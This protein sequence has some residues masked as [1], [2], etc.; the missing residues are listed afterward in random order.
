MKDRAASVRARLTDKARESGRPFSEL[1][2][3]YAMERF[4]YR[5]SQLPESDRLLLKG[6]LMLQVWDAPDSRPTRDIDLLAY[7]NNE[8]Q[9]V[10]ALARAACEI[11]V[12]DDGMVFDSATISGQR[13]KEDAD[14]EGVRVRLTGRLSNARVPIQLDVGFGDVVYPAAEEADYPVLLD[15]PA[16]S[17]RVYPRETLIAEKYEAMVRLGEVNSRVKDFFDIWLL[18]RQFD[19]SGD[20]LATAITKTF[21]NRKTEPPASTPVALTE[22]FSSA[23]R[24]Q[25][26]WAA[27]LRRSD[28]AIAPTKF[29]D[30]V[31]ELRVFLLPPSVAAA[32]GEQLGY[33][34]GAAGS[35][36]ISRSDNR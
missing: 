26:L 22:A 24:S 7:L 10:E 6:A 3:Y 30:V 16:P 23:D 32:S 35:W 25:G 34:W 28:I 8:V 14:Y 17:L 1:L 4:L 31:A 12:I 27:F 36:T 21:A 33:D 15:A 5:L 9:A 18:A 13:I 11:E 20:A 29:S 19:F 2:Q